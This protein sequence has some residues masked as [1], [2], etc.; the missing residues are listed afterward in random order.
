MSQFAEY[1]TGISAQGGKRY[2]S[3]FV[4]LRRQ[5]FNQR[6]GAAET[7]WAV[8]RMAPGLSRWNYR[9]ARRWRP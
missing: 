6:L 4:H 7:P 1:S 3:G 2:P 9:V 8:S 5:L